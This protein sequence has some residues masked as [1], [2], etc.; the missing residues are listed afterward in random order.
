MISQAGLLE[1]E[2]QAG[3]DR[4]RARGVVEARQC[5]IGQFEVVD[6]LRL[7][8]RGGDADQLNPL[9]SPCWPARQGAAAPVPAT[10]RALP[11]AARTSSSLRRGPCHSKGSSHQS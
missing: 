4:L 10:K 11:S 7:V 8:A 5:S 6:R 2:R 3:V 9:R 1:V